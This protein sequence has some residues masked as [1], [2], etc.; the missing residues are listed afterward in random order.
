M[1]CFDLP[2]LSCLL[3]RKLNFDGMSVWVG[4]ILRKLDYFVTTAMWEIEK[5]RRM[6]K[7]AYRDSEGPTCAA[8]PPRMDYNN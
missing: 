6:R 4:N 2:E 8:A 1:T 3:S 5:E 7:K